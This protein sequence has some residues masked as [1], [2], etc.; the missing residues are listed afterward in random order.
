MTG[1]A[2]YGVRVGVSLDGDRTAN[3]RHRRFADGRSSHK[4]AMRA[5]AL[6]RRPD[7]RHLYAGIL[8]TVD[9]ANDPITV[10]EAVLARLH[11]ALTSC[12]PMPR[13]IIRREARPACTRPTPPGS[14]RST[15]GG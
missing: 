14:G 5:L 4:Q 12:C 8:C 10:Y 9:V 6:L 15:P 7:Y 1:S 11:R 3:D 13:G 2:E